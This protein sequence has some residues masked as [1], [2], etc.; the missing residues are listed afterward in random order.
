MRP[1]RSLHA[2]GSQKIGQQEEEYLPCLGGVGRRTHDLC[3][4]RKSCHRE[5]LRPNFGV[6]SLGTFFPECR[7]YSQHLP[8]GQERGAVAVNVR[9]LGRAAA[10]INRAGAYTLGR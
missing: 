10:T 5:A 6:G 3:C 1:R 8:S 9:P 7:F 4:E 2:Y